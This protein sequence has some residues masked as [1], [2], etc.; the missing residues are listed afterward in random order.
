MAFVF[1]TRMGEA[2]EL[3]PAR[4]AMPAPVQLR[5]AHE[6]LRQLAEGGDEP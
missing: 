5:D 4:K 1:F 2:S 6:R 3:E